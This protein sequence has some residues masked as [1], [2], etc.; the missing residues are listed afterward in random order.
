VTSIIGV[1][2]PVLIILAM[3]IVGLELTLADL[4]RVWHYPVHVAVTVLAQILV[5]PLIAVALIVLLHAEPDVAA[6]LILAAAAPQALSSN[7]YC[8]L[9]RADIAL[10]VTLTAVSSVVAVVSTPLV[11]GVGFGLLLEQQVGL[12]LPA[13]KVMQQIVTGLLLPIAAGMLVRRYAPGFVER[14]RMRFQRASLI[15]IGAMVVI[16]LVDQ[17]GTIRRNLATIVFAAVFFTAG[18]AALGLGLARAFSWNREDTITMVAAF[19]SRSLSIATLIALNVLGRPDFL[20]F[21]VIFFL[22]QSLLLVPTMLLSR[23]AGL[24]E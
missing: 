14:N 12:V 19:P 4:G 17:A 5:L 11:A 16:L 10:S 1:G 2:L 13:G 20:S 21:V 15:A 3:T 18:A 7:Y 24:R 9:A 23:S 8:L 6:G 22:V